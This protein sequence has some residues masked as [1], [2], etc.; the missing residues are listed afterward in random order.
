M[1]FGL[2]SPIYDNLILL[3]G[4]ILSVIS[5][6]F[7]LSSLLVPIIITAAISVIMSIVVFGLTKVALRDQTSRSHFQKA[8]IT[9]PSQNTPR[10]KSKRHLSSLKI[11]FLCVYIISLLVASLTSE[12]NKQ[13][14]VSWDQF[15]LSQIVQ[16]GSC[17]FTL[18]L[19]TRICDSKYH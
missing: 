13:L 9:E 6:F 8:R 15:G 10:H 14:F 3:P 19:C 1:T 12:P 11:I 7:I 16:F 2:L 17:N 5:I 18:F 4:V